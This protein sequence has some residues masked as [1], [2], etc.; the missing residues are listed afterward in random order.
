MEYNDILTFSCGFC[1][2]KKLALEVRS[3]KVRINDNMRVTLLNTPAYRCLE[4]DVIFSSIPS[5]HVEP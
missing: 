5:M 1:S 3:Y 4:C 2:S